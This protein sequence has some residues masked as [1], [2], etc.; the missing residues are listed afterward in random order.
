MGFQ[1]VLLVLFP[2]LPLLPPSE[3]P[4]SYR[5]ECPEQCQPWMREEAYAA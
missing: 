2:L 1:V 4:P 5:I 3:A